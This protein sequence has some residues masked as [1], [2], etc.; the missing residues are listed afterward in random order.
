MITIISFF[1]DDF[2]FLNILEGILITVI[3]VFTICTLRFFIIS[4]YLSLVF[5]LILASLF[6]KF[7]YLNLKI[8]LV[9]FCIISN[10]ILGFDVKFIVE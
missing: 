8:W 10:Y 6:F 4:F 1:F 5:I 3:L 2:F 7:C 9:Y